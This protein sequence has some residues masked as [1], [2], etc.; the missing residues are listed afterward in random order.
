MNRARI[1]VAGLFAA[2]LS[3][4]AAGPGGG[5]AVG[6][7]PGPHTVRP[8]A[9]YSIVARD[10][11]TG[12]MGVAVQ[13]HW[14]SV[15]P[16]V[17]WAEAGVGAVATQ[18]LVEVSYGPKGLGLMRGGVRAGDALD[19]LL[20]QD[21]G[22]ALRQVAMVD[23]RGGAAVHTGERCI[24][25]AGH[26]IQKLADGTAYACQANLMRR[27]GVPEAMGAAFEA[28]ADRPLA[29]R[30]AAALRAA[31]GAGGDIRGKQS[32]A[33]IVVRAEA[34]ERPWA[35]RLVDLRIEDHADPIAELERLLRL[36]RA[37]ERMN[38][39]DL[40]MER[41]DVDGAVREFGAAR[42]LAPGNSEM[43][44]WAA[45]ALIG[46]GRVGEAEPLLREAYRDTAGDWRET[47]RR[48]PRS[49]LLPDD[50]ALIERLAGL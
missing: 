13:S 29:E 39:G 19:E 35:D 31:E 34:S 6:V 27:K 24:A 10:G 45:V 11:K 17:P 26:V 46:A 32:A 18:S 36:H 14:F 2:A 22:E 8:V 3:G 1:I 43:A 47:L 12:E 7:A 4:C 42:A 9:T 38:A 23:A 28:T 20:G 40:A 37:Y 41:G 25:E 30:L 44:F 49:G 50:A 16:I 21:E 48:L 5:N 33:L 15:G